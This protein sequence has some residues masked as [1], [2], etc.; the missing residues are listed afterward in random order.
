MD[1]SAIMATL[2]QDEELW[3]SQVIDHYTAYVTAIIGGISKG[4]L[5]AS[6]IEEAAAD[7]FFKLWQ[8]RKQ[9]RGGSMKAFIAKLAR[10]LSRPAT[11]PSIP[12]QTASNS[13]RYR[14]ARTT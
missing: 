6:D 10:K 11:V 4:A 14:S 9:I 7:V 12:P 2:G 1:D 8:K 5:S 13:L 3:Y